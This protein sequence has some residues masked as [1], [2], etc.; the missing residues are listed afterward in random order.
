MIEISNL[1][2]I[3]DNNDNP[4]GI[5]DIN[6]NIGEKG[7]YIIK[8]ESGSGKTT[9][10][11]VIGLI[12]SFNS[13][14]YIFNGQSILDC[15][16]KT[17]ENIRRN[18]ISFIFQDFKLFENLTVYENIKLAA[19]GEIDEEYLNS[20]LILTNL[21][22]V[23]E[24]K[25]KFLSS[26]QQQRVA[27]I[28]SF[29]KK[30]KLIIADEPTGNLD[31][32]NSIQIMDIIKTISTT[33][34]VVL[35]THNS[36]LCEQYYDYLIELKD[37]RIV[38]SKERINKDE[39]LN[40]SNNLDNTFT[41]TK[42]R[43]K[44]NFLLQRILSKNIIND[45]LLILF[46]SISTI[47]SSMIFETL[48]HNVSDIYYRS[49]RNTNEDSALLEYNGSTNGYNFYDFNNDVKL[50]RYYELNVHLPK[51]W[52]NSYESTALMFS[53]DFEEKKFDL[54]QGRLPKS[55]NECIVSD[56][57][58]SVF[59]NP[60]SIILSF[61]SNNNY[62][63][64][65]VC[66]VGVYKT[67]YTDT[68]WNSTNNTLKSVFINNHFCKIYGIM[69]KLY[70]NNGII[71]VGGFL[72]ESSNTFYYKIGNSTIFF[73]EIDI[74]KGRLPTNKTEVLI[75]LNNSIDVSELNS[76]IALNNN[77]DLFPCAYSMT[78]NLSGEYFNYNIFTDYVTVVGFY[79]YKESSIYKENEEYND[80]VLIDENT[81]IIA[82]E[83]SLNYYN[84]SCFFI[85]TTS[86]N[87]KHALD[88][89]FS[90][91]CYSD[92][93]IKS[94]L[95]ALSHF[96]TIGL[97]ICALCFTLLLIILL[98]D[99]LSLY[100]KK[101]FTIATL[102]CLGFTKKEINFSILINNFIIL[103]ISSIISSIALIP[104]LKIVNFS[105]RTEYTTVSEFLAYPVWG[106]FASISISAIVIFLVVMM[107]LKKVRKNNIIWWQKNNN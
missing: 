78:T 16:K 51:T 21:T 18:D 57:V 89:G 31:S 54:V 38:N 56:Y 106:L 44:F 35:V 60:S 72:P 87:I 19:F 48:T 98:K 2:K 3:Y 66:I 6:L 12:D 7:L 26:G 64:N 46:L 74:V 50:D 20:L 96:K 83:L 90:V 73:E 59:N 29:I 17:I 93:D 62:I 71:S 1:N 61:N 14:K 77:E 70:E 24:K 104:A 52:E 9:L 33:I 86:F 5:F 75:P 41:P 23:K 95:T 99:L 92:N 49:T 67:F 37:G 30:P 40:K 27:I 42:E 103:F 4:L 84:Y 11:N 25:V 80:L 79:E 101:K 13:G 107:S 10:L 28:R 53:D 94:T 97:V 81:F 88:N 102:L 45:V 69:D 65:D 82:D 100:S 8:G 68:N 15:D 36:T 105:F 85:D 22:K 91:R 32:K 58:Y 39:I 43:S 55:N 63:K 34:P 47:I 76:K